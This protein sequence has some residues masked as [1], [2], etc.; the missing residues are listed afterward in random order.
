MS[1]DDLSTYCRLIK[2][3]CDRTVPLA[4]R[5]QAAC[6]A[7]DFEDLTHKHTATAPGISYLHPARMEARWQR[8][9]HA[10]LHAQSI[11]KHLY[12]ATD[13]QVEGR[14]ITVRI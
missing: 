12:G 7:S 5:Y 3:M 6:D 1:C 9:V 8:H 14:V 2:F 13:I 4:D 11:L 10:A